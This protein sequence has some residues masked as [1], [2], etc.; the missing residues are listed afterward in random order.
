[1]QYETYHKK[2]KGNPLLGWVGVLMFVLIASV[3]LFA[4]TR[5]AAEAA[6]ADT[7]AETEKVGKVKVHYLTIEFKQ[8]SFT[9]S[10]S[11]H[12]KDAANAFSITL[13][14]TE[15][16]YNSVKVGDELGSKFKGASFLLSGN[17]GSRKV[18]VK[19]KFTK[20]E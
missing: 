6:E 12:I 9:L 2:S 15:K 20:M 10:I 5:P 3:A 7:A 13:P 14:T 17:I 16:F 8:S 11:Q 18:V 19:D 4:A 1:M